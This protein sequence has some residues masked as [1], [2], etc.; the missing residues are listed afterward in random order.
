MTN[1][2]DHANKAFEDKNFQHALDLYV[3]ETSARPQN[4]FAHERVA[5][6]LLML[7]RP[8]DAVAAC[9][10]ILALDPNHIV[11]HVIMAEAYYDMKEYSKS[12]GEIDIA[13]AMDPSNPEVLVSYGTLLLFENKAD[14]A[15]SFLESAIQKDPNNYTA[16]N[17][18][19]VIYVTKRNK[20][21]VLYCAKEMYR[22][23]RTTKNFIRLLVG[24]MDYLRLTNILFVF[25]VTLIL[26]SE[27]FRW[28]AVFWGTGSIILALIVLRRYLRH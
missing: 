9:E 24:Y 19:A 28:W 7:N 15:L 3:Q 21:K 6:C 2:I 8:A 26:V 4:L 18:L 10:K 17:N 1:Q 13:Y 5:R 23:R 14:E 27:I 11:A 12:M 16:Y 20:E 22:L 25:L